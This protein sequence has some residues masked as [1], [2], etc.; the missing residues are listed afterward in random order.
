MAGLCQAAAVA[1][2]EASSQQLLGAQLALLSPAHQVEFLGKLARV[3]SSH[4]ARLLATYREDAALA[5]QLQQYEGEYEQRL[6][7]L[8]SRLGSGLRVL[9]G[10]RDRLAPLQEVA[11]ASQCMMRELQVAYGLVLQRLEALEGLAAAGM[12][13]A[14][15][16]GDG[17][18]TAAGGGALAV[19]GSLRKLQ[20]D[21]LALSRRLSAAES[22]LASTSECL[23]VS[24][25]LAARMADADGRNAQLAGKVSSMATS[26][27]LMAGRMGE[28]EGRLARSLAVARR[29]LELLADQLVALGALNGRASPNKNPLAALGPY[30][31]AMTALE[32]KVEAVRTAMSAS[33]GLMMA[34]LAAEA[35]AGSNAA[36]GGSAKGGQAGIAADVAATQQAASDA[37]NAAVASHQEALMGLEGKVLELRAELRSALA[38]AGRQAQLE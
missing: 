30:H 35:A 18:E 37:V 1:T 13:S 3:V 27:P 10:L 38:A 6:A 4:A 21:V 19:A 34:D 29:G 12:G 9:A 26:L 25:R 20:D 24:R 32:G 31:A 8:E 28:L 23:A 33:V 36:A 15:S 17:Q 22:S 11:D 5:A 14:G 16:S 7:A 2:E